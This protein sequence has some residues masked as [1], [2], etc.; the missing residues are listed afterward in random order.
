MRQKARVYAA[1]RECRFWVDGPTLDQAGCNEFISRALKLAWVRDRYKRPKVTRFYPKVGDWSF[2]ASGGMG[3]ARK[4]GTKKD[5]RALKNYFLPGERFVQLPL[6][7]R[8]PHV[9][10]HELSHAFEYHDGHGEDFCWCFL[11]LVKDMMGWW[12]REEL[13]VAMVRNK[14]K[15]A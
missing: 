3:P 13:K 12:P 15:I 14:V 8:N 9:I 10:C 6:W 5:V 4:L 1:E 2:P 7:A 11:R